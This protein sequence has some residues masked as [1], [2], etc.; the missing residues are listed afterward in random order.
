MIAN[1]LHQWLVKIALNQPWAS[2]IEQNYSQLM[3]THPDNSAH[4][5]LM[6]HI[7]EKLRLMTTLSIKSPRRWEII[8]APY[9]T[10]AVLQW[11]DITQLYQQRTLLP[12]MR[13]TG[14]PLILN[15]IKLHAPDYFQLK[16]ITADELYHSF[17]SHSSSFF[18][19]QPM[20]VVVFMDERLPMSFRQPI[21]FNKNRF[22][23]TACRAQVLNRLKLSITTLLPVNRCLEPLYSITGNRYQSDQYQLAV[24]DTF[25]HL[26]SFPAPWGKWDDISVLLHG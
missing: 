25:K 2:R 10:P 6:E 4:E 7:L 14:L 21:K 1:Y 15:Q 26:E 19:Q 20:A 17:N 18:S 16:I 11:L 12:L 9:L 23:V 8:S 3:G 13:W 24:N 5:W 22:F